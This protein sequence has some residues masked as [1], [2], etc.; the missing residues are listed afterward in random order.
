MQT[1]SST[2]QKWQHLSAQIFVEGQ[3]RL[4]QGKRLDII[5]PATEEM[6]GQAAIATPTEIDA[7]IA[8]ANRS[9]QEWWG[10]SALERADRLHE[11][12]AKLQSMKVEL[13]ELLTREMGKPYKESADEVEWSVTAIRYYAEV[14]RNEAGKVYGPA[15]AGQ[16]HFTMKEPLGTVVSILPFNYPIV[17]FAWQ[18]GAALAT[19]NAVIVKPSELTTMTTLLLMEAFTTLPQGLVQCLPGDA[20][21]GV[22]LTESKETHM[23]AFT[24]GV[25][26]GQAVATACAPQ[27]KRTLIEASGNDPFLVM[28]SAPLAI[29]ARGAAF[30]AFLNC[31]QVCTS[32]E[33]F[34]VHTDIYD[35]FVALVVQEVQA[36]R[37]GNGLGKVDMGP[38]AT[39]KAR[40]KFAA[41]IDN[42][43]AQGAKVACGGKRPAGLD[44]GWFYEPTV[45]VDVTPDMDIVNNEPFGP[46]APIVRVQNLDEAIAWANRSELGLGGNIYTMR[47]DEAMKATNQLQV[48]MVWVNAPLLDNDAGPFGGRKMTGL[49]REL[50]SEGLE[51][52][53]QTKLV[54]IDPDA[55][56]HDFWWF[57]YSDKE[58]FGGQQ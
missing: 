47:L 26:A 58:A 30:A 48:G 50:G 31:G 35:E 49:G 36:L 20:S 32:A 18:A 9:Q 3:L 24:G 1:F 7:A 45:L 41:M 39:E 53:R 44:K 25:A 56:A 46:V 17:L 27:F 13:A 14:A 22:R 11:V 19:G 57:P 4:S 42:A 33:R 38:M 37:M 54:M 16:L 10:L 21:V 23:V 28:P 29:A 6:L 34:Y 52:F 40:D 2:T 43:I 55:Q 5:D 12:A 15:V 51:N 8:S